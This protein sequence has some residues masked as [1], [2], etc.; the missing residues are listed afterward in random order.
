MLFGIR[1]VLN[2]VVVVLLCT[3]LNLSTS[4]RLWRFYNCYYVTQMFTDVKAA[5]PITSLARGYQD[6][7]FH[8]VVNSN[9][10]IMMLFC[11]SFRR[12]CLTQATHRPR[13]VWPTQLR[14]TLR[15]H[16]RRSWIPFTDK[17]FPD[18]HFTARIAFGALIYLIR[19]DTIT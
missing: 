4:G 8:A 18:C 10:N 19:V 2:V 6:G 7:L 9:I 17:T 12:L 15:H 11:S 13:H 5:R 14:I 16:L 1:L 3:A